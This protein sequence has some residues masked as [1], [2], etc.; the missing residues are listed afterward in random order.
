MIVNEIEKNR[1]ISK[2]ALSTMVFERLN[3]VVSRLQSGYVARPPR[4]VPLIRKS[5]KKN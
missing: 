5:N 4:K 3:L 2:Q 1:Y